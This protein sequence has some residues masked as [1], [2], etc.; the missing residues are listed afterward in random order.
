M[1]I[2]ESGPVGGKTNSL[3]AVVKIVWAAAPGKAVAHLSLNILGG[4]LPVLTG[5]LVKVALDRLSDRISMGELLVPAVALAVVGVVQAFSQ[6]AINYFR[7]DL[8]RVT[9]IIAQGNLFTSV[10]GFVGLARLED[11]SFLD[12]LRLASMSGRRSTNEV[13]EGSLGFARAVITSIGFLT[14]LTVIAPVMAAFLLIFAVPVLM[15]ELALSRRRA[16]ML[17]RISSHERRE[18]FYDQ[19]LTSP[20]AAKEVRLFGIG[21]FLLRRMQTERRHADRERRVVDRRE[22]RT[23]STLAA[24]SASISGAGLVWALYASAHGSLS[25]G[26]VSIFIAAVAG[27]QA[28]AAALAAEG[29]RVHHA[30]AL[31]QHYREI[32]CMASDLPR[33]AEPAA[34][35]PLRRGIEFQNVWFRYTEDQPWV[36]RGLNL[37]IPEGAAIG[38]VGVNGAGKSTLVKLLCRFYDPGKGAILWDGVDLR[39][40]SPEDLRQ[41]IGAVFQDYMSYDLSVRENIGIGDL[42]RLDDMPAIMEAA[43]LADAHETIVQLPHGYDTAITRIFFHG[44][45][46]DSDESSGV[47]LSGGQAQRV[48]LARALLR[49]DRDLLILDEPSSGMDAEAEHEMQAT[50]R[51]LRKGKTSLLISHRLGTLREADKI[52][53][54]ADGVIAEDGTHK[55][56]LGRAG[57]YAR[58]FTLQSAGYQESDDALSGRVGP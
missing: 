27:V 18:I 10:N 53:V 56:L 15:A 11:P 21:S 57:L 45:E 34:V 54:L 1:T 48:A 12:R 52:V 26:D 4:V 3:L 7:A 41:R 37:C 33:S 29:A 32:A 14:S 35:L 43:K 6:H 40:M 36:L 28:A 19:L 5:W 2:T 38:I 13:L 24:L 44:P 39:H 46:D 25:L 20:E 55:E 9:S 31:F 30:L 50:L 47:C 23:Q 22:F 17:L 51:V 49:N 58:L 42:S 8:S 16:D